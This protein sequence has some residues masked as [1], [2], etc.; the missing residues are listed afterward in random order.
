MARIAICNPSIEPGDA[1][2]H[3]MLGME[4]VLS[5][6]EHEVCLFSQYTAISAPFIEPFERLSLFLKN[7]EDLL[8]YHYATGWEDG[9]RLMKGLH[10]RKAVKYHN[11]TPPEFFMGVNEDYVG[12]CRAGR[13]QLAD[14]AR[15]DAGLFMPCSEFS[16][17]DLLAAGVSREKCHVVPPFHKIDRLRE[18]EADV[19]LLERHND[20]EIRVL[21]VGRLAPNKNHG[22]L[23][24]SFLAYSRTYNPRSLLFIVGGEDPKLK[25]YTENLVRSVREKRLEEQVVFTGKVSDAALKAYYLLAHVFVITSQHEGFCVPLVEAM[26]MKIPVVAYG[27]TAVPQT[28]GR[29]GLVWE[30]CD[31]QLIAASIHRIVQDETLRTT[32]G[33]LGYA[34]YIEMFTNEKIGQAFMKALGTLL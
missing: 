3:D 21:M 34:R 6:Q 10:C 22:A 23:I 16:L 24:E 9:L 13:R 7:P 2:S 25:A 18:V 28:L 33:E 31:P 8:I 29:A 17:Q 15:T 30:E 5:A 26:S 19:N 20:G 4:E 14:M 1:V 12:V 27:S 32:L 11:V